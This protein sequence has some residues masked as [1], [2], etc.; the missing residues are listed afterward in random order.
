MKALVSIIA[1][2][3]AIVVAGPAFAGDATIPKT[4][5]ECEKAGG[6]WDAAT[7]KCTVAEKK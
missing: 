7:D 1:L 4:K 5:G 2:A 6:S 3:V